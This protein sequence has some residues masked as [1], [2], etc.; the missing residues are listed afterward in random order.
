MKNFIKNVSII[1]LLILVIVKRPIVINA[2]ILSLNLWSKK[3]FPSI[4]PIMIIS[5]LMLSSNIIEIISNSIGKIFTKLFKTSKYAAYVFLL[6]LFSGS[7]TNAKYINDLLINN[8]IDKK[9]AVK[10][11]SMCYLYNPLLIM[12]ITGFLNYHDQLFLIISNVIINLIIGLINRNYKTYSLNKFN[13]P[14]KFNLVES[15]NKAINILLLILGSVAIFIGLSAIIPVNHPLIKGIF[16]LTNGLSSLNSFNISYNYKLLFA[17]I[18]LS[19]GGLSII[20][21]IKSIFKDTIDLTLFYKSRII[22]LILFILLI[23]IKTITSGG[24]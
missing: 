19:F 23:Y 3:L 24:V 11:L 2:L 14:I 8:V 4:L 17:G 15:I 9:E 12:S 13:K 20:T 10:I 7:P 16:E 18:L 1:I 6:S 5:D 22:H 21:Q